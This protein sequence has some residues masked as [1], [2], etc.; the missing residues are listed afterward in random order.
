M[1]P[2]N[3]KSVIVKALFT[4]SIVLFT[5]QLHAM[6]LEIKN[7]EPTAPIQH[8]GNADG[9]MYFRIKY[10]N[11]DGNK[12]SIIVKDKKGN[13]YF[14]RVY[15]RKNFDLKLVLP[16]YT[17]DV[18]FQIKDLSKGNTETYEVNTKVKVIEE[19]IISKI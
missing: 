1:K 2:L 19:V 8:L 18:F 11:A 14:D 10:P 5:S 12:F 6:P 7:P 16:R 17:D 15:N 9:K 13:V 3:L 4:F